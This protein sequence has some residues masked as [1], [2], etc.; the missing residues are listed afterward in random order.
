MK[1]IKGENEKSNTLVYIPSSK[2]RSRFDILGEDLMGEEDQIM[3]WVE[4]EE[5]HLKYMANWKG[6]TLTS[7][8]PVHNRATKNLQLN[9]HC[10]IPKM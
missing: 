8:I 6:T 5:K 3:Q 9:L 1:I 10:L 4:V 2:S 7:R